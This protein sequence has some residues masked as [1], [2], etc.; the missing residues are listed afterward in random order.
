MTGRRAEVVVVAD[1]EVFEK[2]H[3]HPLVLLLIQMVKASD[4]HPP[5]LG[6]SIRSRETGR[7]E[8]VRFS[9]HGYLTMQQ[10]DTW[11]VVDAAETR[12]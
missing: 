8:E 3:R 11:P 4:F 10:G 9:K 5:S 2:A 6:K 7:G 1:P 12:S